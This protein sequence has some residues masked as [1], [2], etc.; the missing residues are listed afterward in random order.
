MSHL[1]FLV[2][3]EHKTNSVFLL[4]DTTIATPFIINTREI[5]SLLNNCENNEFSETR[6]VLDNKKHIF[7]TL[8]FY[9]IKEKIML[10]YKKMFLNTCLH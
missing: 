9:I 5:N 1:Y 2:V 10:E 8:G 4:I 6:V 3:C 7:Q